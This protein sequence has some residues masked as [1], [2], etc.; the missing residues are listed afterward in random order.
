MSYIRGGIGE[1]DEILHKRHCDR[2][3]KGVVWTKGMGG[4]LAT[5]DVR[6]GP[7]TPRKFGESFVVKVDG[8]NLKKNSKVGTR[9]DVV[10]VEETDVHS[11]SR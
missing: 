6:I 4:E 1:D 10:F 2:V 5:M 7:V 3:T 9:V 11:R 8:R